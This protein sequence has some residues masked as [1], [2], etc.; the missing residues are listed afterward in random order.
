MRPFPENFVLYWHKT[1]Y[2]HN[3]TMTARDDFNSLFTGLTLEAMDQL[4]ELGLTVSSK[5][6][7]NLL[8]VEASRRDDAA[9]LI[10]ES[11]ENGVE[12][13]LAELQLTPHIHLG[14]SNF[15]TRLIDNGTIK[16]YK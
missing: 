14:K 3:V 7:T 13:N 9:N 8:K 4:Q 1:K 12:I 16:S 10:K 5:S 2:D 15:P 11:T 6:L